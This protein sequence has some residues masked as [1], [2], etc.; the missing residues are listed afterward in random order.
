MAAPEVE[1]NVRVIPAKRTASYSVPLGKGKLVGKVNLKGISIEAPS[2][3]TTALP[4][5]LAAID[6]LAAL[7]AA[8]RAELVEQ[9][10][11][12]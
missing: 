3:Y 12:E 7:V 1:A 10:V 4:R 8:M 11:T 6:A 2:T 5:T 9:G